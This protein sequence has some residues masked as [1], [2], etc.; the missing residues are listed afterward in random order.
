MTPVMWDQDATLPPDETVP[1]EVA[2]IGTVDAL[3][4][5][6]VAGAAELAI[7]DAP[8]A[9]PGRYLAGRRCRVPA[10]P[11]ILVGARRADGTVRD[12]VVHLA[13]DPIA[14]A[15]PRYT[16]GVA[17]YEAATRPAADPAPAGYAAIRPQ[18]P[19]EQRRGHSR[20]ALVR[21][22]LLVPQ[23]T[24]NA[25]IDGQTRDLSPGGARISGVGRLRP[26]DRLRLLLELGPGALVD[27]DGEIVRVDD[28][29]TAGVR[30]DRLGP[31]DRTVLAR[32]L[33]ARQAAALAEL[34]AAG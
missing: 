1:L 21:P 22:V 8:G 11:G 4:V 10:G 12:D 26:G 31:R 30:F 34:R 28:Q 13:L 33:R 18:S 29:G 17:A 27:G 15:A 23:R 20:V 19:A 14:G 7:I 16:G 32:Y 2:G 5:R 25:W 24:G 3:V 9:L 6:A